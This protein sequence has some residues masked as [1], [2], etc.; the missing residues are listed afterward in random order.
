MDTASKLDT[1]RTSE[2]FRKVPHSD[3]RAFAESLR[4]EHFRANEAVCM[5]GDVAD[6][7]FIVASGELGIWIAGAKKGSKKKVRTLG[8]GQ[9]IGEYGLFTGQVRNA[10]VL[11]ETDAVLL[12][13]EY[14]RFRDFLDLFPGTTYALLEETVHRLLAAQ[15]ESTASR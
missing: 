11:C 9:L 13:V 2:L 1:L 7:I 6:R 3:L 14:D 10:D 8:R 4:V 15:S 5:L 12:S